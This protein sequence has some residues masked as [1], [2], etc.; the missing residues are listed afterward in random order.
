MPAAP[1]EEHDTT[2]E[3][4]GVQRVTRVVFT[5]HTRWWQHGEEAAT[6][7][8]STAYLS[9]LSFIFTMRLNTCKRC[10]SRGQRHERHAEGAP[11]LMAGFAVLVNDEISESGLRERWKRCSRVEAMQ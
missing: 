8:R 6:I 11:H 3:T 4:G 7:R 5:S 2:I 10:V 9:L 1:K